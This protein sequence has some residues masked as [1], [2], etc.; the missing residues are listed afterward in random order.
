VSTK[1]QLKIN[2]NNK[3]QKYLGG[4]GRGKMLNIKCAK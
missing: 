2:N 3:W 4:V 1:L